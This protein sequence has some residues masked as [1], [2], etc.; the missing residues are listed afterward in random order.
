MFDGADAAERGG[1]RRQGRV[2]TDSATLGSG[3]RARDRGATAPGEGCRPRGEG[4]VTRDPLNR[5]EEN[6]HEAVVRLMLD[7]G[8]D[9]SPK[10]EL[11]RT[12]LHWAARRGNERC[13]E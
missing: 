13:T 7:K 8:I 5:A 4:K 6:G 9:V 10:N 3:E 2:R 11:G 12:P 1:H